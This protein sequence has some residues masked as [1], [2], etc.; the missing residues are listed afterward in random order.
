M[1][2]RRKPRKKRV[3]VAVPSSRRKR[4]RT[5]T[6][7]RAIPSP[8]PAV[9]AAAYAIVNKIEKT[10]RRRSAAAK[11]GWVKRRYRETVGPPKAFAVRDVAVEFGNSQAAVDF[12]RKN[13]IPPW[14]WA[15]DVADEFDID[16]HPLWEAYYDTDPATQGAIQ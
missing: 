2:R 14:E 9:I 15:D 16:V 13:L 8:S 7:R 12:A 1:A 11:R 3:P 5:P 10:K 6:P 4:T